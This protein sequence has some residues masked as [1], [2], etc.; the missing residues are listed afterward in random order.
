MLVAG[1]NGKHEQQRR[2]DDEGADQ[3]AAAG[4]CRWRNKA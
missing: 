1:Q 2:Q 4:R 3:E